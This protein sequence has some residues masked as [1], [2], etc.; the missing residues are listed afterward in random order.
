MKGGSTK[1]AARTKSGE[2]EREYD[3]ESMP[4]GV[5]GKYAEYLRV[6]A[7]LVVLDED[8]AEAFPTSAAVNEAL[9]VV[10]QAAACVRRPRKPRVKGPTRSGK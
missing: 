4:G 9:R 10:L 2:M 6:G 1:K 5:R 7:K 3:F 8:V